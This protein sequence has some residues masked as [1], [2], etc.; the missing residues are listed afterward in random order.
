MPRQ[1]SL[2]ELAG[3]FPDLEEWFSVPTN[4]RAQLKEGT[5][6]MSAQEKVLRFGGE[7]QIKNNLDSLP[8]TMKRPYTILTSCRDQPMVSREISQFAE[9]V[10]G[11]QELLT[12]M[13][14]VNIDALIKRGDLNRVAGLTYVI[15]TK[16]P[17]SF[18]LET[19]AGYLTTEEGGRRIV[20]SL[21]QIPAD[22]EFNNGLIPVPFP[23]R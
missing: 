7:N 19:R 6:L 12:A 10:G 18:L 9:I 23:T 15:R 21:S 2:V 5:R 1:L 13:L 16:T 8:H 4:I 3:E 22:P 14:S 17:D 20:E 11:P